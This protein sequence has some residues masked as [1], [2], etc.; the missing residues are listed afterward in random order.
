M[1]P[2]QAIIPADVPAH[3]YPVQPATVSRTPVS[4]VQVPSIP[5]ETKICVAATEI[6]KSWGLAHVLVDWNLADKYVDFV[7][8]NQCASSAASTVR[9]TLGNLPSDTAAETRFG[10]YCCDISLVVNRT[11]KSTWIAKSTLCHEF[12]HVLGLPHISGTVDTCMTAVNNFYRTRPTKLDTRLVNGY[13][14]WGFEKMY[15][16]SGKDVDVRG[17]PG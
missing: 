3:R 1:G 6:P 9:V 2:T 12:G 16:L 15:E 14:T 17:Q 4:T 13:G 8:S 7:L 11:L 10:S 5:P